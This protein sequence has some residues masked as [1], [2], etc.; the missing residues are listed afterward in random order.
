MIHKLLI[1]IVVLTLA[2]CGNNSNRYSTTW[3]STNEY[4]LRSDSNK[5]PKEIESDSTE[6][7][8]EKVIDSVLLAKIDVAKFKKYGL[9]EVESI[10]PFIVV[11]N[12]KITLKNPKNIDAGLNTIRFEEWTE[13]QWL[14]NNYIRSVRLY[15]DAYNLGIVKEDKFDKYKSYMQGKFAVCEIDPFLGGGAMIYIV[16]MDNPSF[17]LGFWVYSFIEYSSLALS[18]YEIRHTDLTSEDS[19]YTIEEIEDIMKRYPQHKLW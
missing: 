15:I 14:D 7:A 8:T 11:S 13:E 16:F 19:G 17:V 10:D 2:G 1:V 6:F 9:T 3:S 5:H 4:V 18:G 12:E